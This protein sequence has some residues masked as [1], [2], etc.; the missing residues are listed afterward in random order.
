MTIYIPS[1][2][3]QQV[4]SISKKPLLIAGP[5]S[6]ETEEQVIN[7]AIGLKE[8][9]KVDAFRAGV[10]KPRTR[11]G[12]FEG[13]GIAALPWLQK[14]KAITGLPIAIEVATAKQVE[15]ALQHDIDILWIGARTTVNPFSIQEVA[16]AL[17][18]INKPVFI[19]NP[20]NPD[21]ELW[22][23]AVERIAKAGIQAI[24][25]IH[26]G[27]SSYG[28]AD[29]RNVPM[30]NIAIGMKQRFPDFPMLIDPSH[31]C[32]NTSLLQEIFQKGIDLD[33]DGAIIESHHMPANAWSDA[34]Q[35]V[36]PLQLATIIDQLI[37]KKG[38]IEN[39]VIFA[40]LVAYRDAIDAI[41][42]EL[43]K[44][45]HKRMQISEHIGALKRANNMTILQTQ[46]W[47]NIYERLQNLA[48]Q[49]NLSQEFI[50]HYLEV[51]HLESIRHQEMHKAD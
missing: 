24:G 36:T 20:V 6:A 42:D 40:P 28:N 27:F 44:L 34:K 49:F 38:H 4:F 17:Q 3:N 26:R 39:E 35:Q 15:A 22:T 50:E 37:W 2:M 5:C 46:R 43:I 30:W 33:Y 21:I 45:L 10:W 31:I 11:P 32:G 16:D 12:S 8:I 13:V 41:D 18:H 48:N 23:G 47:K 1:S 14:A 19:K 25:L 29:L 9:G 7:T 51:I